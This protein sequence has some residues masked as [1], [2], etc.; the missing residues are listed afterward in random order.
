METLKYT[1]KKN[2]LARITNTVTVVQY[3][4]HIDRFATWAKETHRIRLASDVLDSCALAQEYAD[5]LCSSGYTP[6]TIHSYMAPVKNSM[7]KLFIH[8]LLQTG[9]FLRSAPKITVC[10]KK[11]FCAPQVA[12]RA[13]CGV[14]CC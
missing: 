4:R 6:D 2:A 7:K 3:K 5:Y 8:Y 12:D 10:S 14:A 1:L 9:Y 13:T 11:C